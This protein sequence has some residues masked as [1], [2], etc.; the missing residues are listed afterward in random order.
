MQVRKSSEQKS[1]LAESK[2]VTIRAE[3]QLLKQQMHGLQAELD[4]LRATCSSIPAEA[5]K[6]KD[7]IASLVPRMLAGGELTNSCHFHLVTCS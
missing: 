7:M 4:Q 2:L 5:T 3:A 1:S 6:F